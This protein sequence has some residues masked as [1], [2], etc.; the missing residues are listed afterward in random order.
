MGRHADGDGSRLIVAGFYEVSGRVATM[1]SSTM[2]GKAS[3][4]VDEF[5]A[6]LAPNVG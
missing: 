5:F 4:I 6:Q 2:G 3:N 1:G